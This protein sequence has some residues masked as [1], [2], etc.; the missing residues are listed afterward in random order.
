M[1]TNYWI[2]A[3][4]ISG[5][6]LPVAGFA[7]MDNIRELQEEHKSYELKFNNR[8]AELEA[9]IADINA[10]T[11]D[12]KQQEKDKDTARDALEELQRLDR[13]NPSLGL[14]DKVSEARK[15]NR[16]AHQ[17]YEKEKKQLDTL[18]EERRDLERDIQKHALK[19]NKISADIEL[20]SRNVIDEEIALRLRDLQ[21][22]KTVEGFSEV[23]CGDESPRKCQ[24]RAR[25][26]AER[27][28]TE[29]GSI[30]VVESV[31][32]IQNF[33]LTEDQVKSEVQAQLS[34]IEVLDKGW[35]N[36][37][38]YR[39]QIRANVTPIITSSLKDK[40]R[41]SIAL[42]KG[43]SIPALVSVETTDSGVI[44]RE[45]SL[46][47]KIERKSETLSRRDQAFDELDRETNSGSGRSSVT[48]QD[49]ES[50]TTSLSWSDFVRE[51]TYRA[52]YFGSW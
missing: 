1:S 19:L 29:K 17:K 26:Q 33:Q 49:G 14:T 44:V 43:I 47:K 25:K 34:D 8:K 3:L 50:D 22:T 32:D 2:S 11:A 23:G 4:L 13:E 41:E 30:T 5:L 15:K 35:A 45:N 12:L 36:D 6:L 18:S 20:E 9:V 31:T 37:T 39:Y 40:M 7:D 16:A 46:D 28:A 42:Q 10:S 21:V 52:R 38:T 48:E 27:D 24:Q 51:S